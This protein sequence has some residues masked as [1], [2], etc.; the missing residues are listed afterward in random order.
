NGIVTLSGEVDSYFKKLKAEEAA[1]KVGGVKAIAEEIQIKVMPLGKL[2][3]ADIA[4]AALNAL[5]WHPAVQ[6]DKIK[7]TVEE[8]R[9][10]L[11][12][13]VDWEFER[14]SARTAIENLAGVKSIA[15][16]ITV[17]PRT[18]PADVHKKITAAF[19]RS[20]TIDAERINVEIIGSKAILKGQVRSLAEKQDAENAAWAAPG[21][22]TVDSN[23]K[24]VVPAFS[25]DE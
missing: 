20:A 19:T 5:K 14:S 10:K 23:L 7:I 15:N 25:Y 4:A 6:Q 24:V 8:G 12:G 9:V 1:K 21:I 13:E 3:D 11:E 18:T 22:T 17:K 2:T 16:F